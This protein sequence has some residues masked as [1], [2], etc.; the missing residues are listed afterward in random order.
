[1]NYIK[2][3]IISMLIYLLMLFTFLIIF[4]VYYD[5]SNIKINDRYLIN[6]KE[7]DLKKKF[8]NENYYKKNMYNFDYSDSIYIDEP[9]NE[10]KKKNDNI[11]IDDDNN[12]EVRK[13][14]F[15]NSDKLTKEAKE[16]IK[17]DVKNETKTNKIISDDDCEKLGLGNCTKEIKNIKINVSKKVLSETLQ[18]EG[19]FTNPKKVQLL[20]QLNIGNVNDI[21]CINSITFGR[22]CNDDDEECLKENNYPPKCCDKND[23]DCKEEDNIWVS[24]G[25]AGIFT[26]KNKIGV[27][28]SP[29]DTTLI[30]QDLLK[31]RNVKVINFCNKVRSDISKTESVLS[32]SLPNFCSSIEDKNDCENKK[33]SFYE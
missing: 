10:E 30:N 26:Y 11:I 22:C 33:K 16:K 12:D 13:D 29:Q 27:C 17:V 3:F 7:N 15:D 25:C 28:Q 5:Y 21:P 2:Y 1:M 32:N 6:K 14:D 31:A 23:P 18:D 4:Y 9:V 19:V 20:N 24:N 8:M